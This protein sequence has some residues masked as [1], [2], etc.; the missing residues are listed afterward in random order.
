[1]CSLQLKKMIKI[2]IVIEC[3]QCTMVSP[4]ISI[5]YHNH[6]FCS[7]NIIVQ[8]LKTAL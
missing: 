2:E 8:L 3:L 6:L 7:Y 5:F 1:M 4:I